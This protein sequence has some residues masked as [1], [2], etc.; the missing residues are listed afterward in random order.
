VVAERWKRW[1]E[2]AIGDEGEWR[3]GGGLCFAQRSLELHGADRYEREGRAETPSDGEGEACK[4]RASGGAADDDQAWRR[5]R[6][7]ALEGERGEVGSLCGRAESLDQV[8]MK[9]CRERARAME[10]Q[11]SRP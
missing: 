1:K 6:S 11:G 8:P 2:R 4:T 3:R 9:P 10:E 7:S 5:H